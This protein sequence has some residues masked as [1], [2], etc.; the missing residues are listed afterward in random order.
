VIYSEEQQGSGGGDKTKKPGEEKQNPRGRVILV[1]QK[2]ILLANLSKVQPEHEKKR[3]GKRGVKSPLPVGVGAAWR[4]VKYDIKGVGG[5]AQGTVIE[6]VRSLKGDRKAYHYQFRGGVQGGERNPGRSR[7]QKGPVMRGGSCI[8]TWVMR[9]KLEHYGSRRTNWEK[10]NW[11][12]AAKPGLDKGMNTLKESCQ[13]RASSSATW[14]TGGPSI[15]GRKKVAEKRNW[16][17]SPHPLN[18]YQGLYNEK[19]LSGTSG[20]GTLSSRRGT[21]FREKVINRTVEKGKDKKGELCGLLR[22][23]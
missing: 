23:Q 9:G 17:R 19:V 12:I 15:R 7:E 11:E 13:F 22:G 4:G 16:E 20:G 8:Q 14:K 21:G 10:A 3:G 1:W 6:G 5:R 18:S 2:I